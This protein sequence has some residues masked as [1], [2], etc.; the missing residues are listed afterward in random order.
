MAVVLT[1]G[2]GQA[3][4]LPAPA[5]YLAPRAETPVV[6]DGLADEAAWQAVPWSDPFVDIRG[7]AFPQPSLETRVKLLWDDQHLYVAAILHEPHLWATLLERDAIIY[8]DDDFEVF[9]D[10][11]G[12][13]LDYYEL[14][15]NAYGTEFDL[16]LNRPYSEGGEAHIPWDMPGLR[17]S[18]FLHGS[19]NDPSDI[20]DGWSVEMAIP[21]EDLVPPGWDPAS[22]PEG[23]RTGRAPEVDD[24]WRVN[25]SR[26]EWPL[27]VENG[28]YVKAAEPV[29]WSDHPEDNWVWSPQWEINMH[30]PSRWGFVWFVDGMW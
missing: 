21:W 23:G 8:R 6:V 13:G 22:A 28:R 17:T 16:F 15:I 24:V 5:T 14:E 26:V 7:P 2:P 25:F 10:P 4:R 12:D 20:D 27:R 30:I 1:A 3:Q 11:D 18:V 19:L 9:V 29:D